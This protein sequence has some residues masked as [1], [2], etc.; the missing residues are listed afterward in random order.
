ELYR[1]Y[2]LY[3]KRKISQI[4]TIYLIFLYISPSLCFAQLSIHHFYKILINA[5][6]VFIQ[7][8]T[9]DYMC[10]ITNFKCYS[11]LNFQNIFTIP[12]F[13]SIF[14][15]ITIS[16]YLRILMKLYKTYLITP[17]SLENEI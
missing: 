12:N 3:Y 14:I 2:H 9:Q 7:R 15:R 16:L 8:I 13:L 5:Y 17:I 10:H 4:L 1:S 11:T 6:F